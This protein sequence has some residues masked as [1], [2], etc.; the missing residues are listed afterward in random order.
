MVDKYFTSSEQIELYFE[1][2]IEEVIDEISYQILDHVI[3]EVIDKAYINET[4]SGNV[5]DLYNRDYAY[6]YDGQ[7]TPTFEFL[8]AFKIVREGVEKG[9]SNL[10]FDGS[11]I[12]T[13]GEDTWAHT[14][15]AS[16]LLVF[17][18]SGLNVGSAGIYNEGGFLYDS[19]E[20]INTNFTKLIKT[21]FSKR[22]LKVTVSF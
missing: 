9:V 20:W 10:V 7:G 8:E 4:Q 13:K 19:Y 12:T 21:S 16:E 6:Y 3:E 17:L 11:V 14:L 22:G 2:L 18:E 5:A 1:S 15:G